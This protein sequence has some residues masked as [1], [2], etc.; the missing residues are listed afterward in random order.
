MTEPDPLTERLRRCYTGVVH[1]AMRA[2]GWRDFVLPQELRPI[3]PDQTL[4]GPVF[5]LSDHIDTGADPHETLLAWTGFLSKAPS[6]HVVVAQPNDRTIANM[7]ELSAETLQQRGVLGYIV[8]GGSR[9]VNFLLRMGF[10]VYCRYFTPR[11]VVGTWLPDGFDVPIRIGD[12]DIEPGEYVC[13]D[14]DGI[15]VIPADRVEAVVEAAEAAI[16]TENKVR[17]AIL[18]GEDPQEAYRKYGKF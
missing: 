14:R 3:L 6:G 9:D 16:A 10:P 15:C 12:V 18:A 11:D 5:T 17:T 2:M 7:G 8:D 13:A 1:D 4:A